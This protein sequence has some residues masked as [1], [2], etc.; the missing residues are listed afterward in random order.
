MRRLWPLA[1]VLLAACGG[2]A[3]SVTTA[4]GTSTNPGAT[5][6]PAFTGSSGTPGPI[7]ATP[8]TG[9]V[10]PAACAAGFIEYLTAI[11]P[12]VADLNPETATLGEFGAADRAAREKGFELL[13]ANESRATYSCS[14]VGLEFNYFDARSPWAAIHEIADAQ[15]PGTAAYLQ[16]KE[17]LSDIETK[18]L[19]DYGSP[20]CDEVVAQIKEAVAQ[21]LAAGSKT[22]NDLGI[23]K[24]LA[25][26]G[27][28][29]AYIADVRAETCPRDALGNDEF[30]F[31]R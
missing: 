30:S 29:K 12:L 17:Q 26:L 9:G 11:E 25:L 24:G 8:A 5:A 23:D 15:A 14:E 27:L 19:A 28:Y 6:G 21:E 20:S 1:L 18:T 22:T 4:P 2:G 3:P 7:Q 13:S 16:V 10:I 31:M